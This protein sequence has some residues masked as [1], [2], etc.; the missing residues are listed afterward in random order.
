[1]L[2]LLKLTKVVAL[3]AEGCRGFANFSMKIISW[4]LRI[5]GCNK[6][7]SLHNQF[8]KVSLDIVIFQVTK[9]DVINTKTIRKFSLLNKKGI[10]LLVGGIFV[11]W[12][13]SLDPC[14]TL[15]AC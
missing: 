4:N 1:M 13:T 10:A 15:L 7:I 12:G 3:G 5:C 6:S 14:L 2:D 9:L 11:I 8:C